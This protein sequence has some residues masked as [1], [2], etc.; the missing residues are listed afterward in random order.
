MRISMQKLAT[1]LAVSILLLAVAEPA[2][3]DTWAHDYGGPNSDNPVDIHQT[4]DGGFL[5]AGDTSYDS[6][7]F[8]EPG[9]YWHL[10]AV[11]IDAS[12]NFLWSGYYPDGGDLRGTG[13]AP[14]SDGGWMLAGN[15]FD[16]H[17]FD[18]DG[19]LLAV[20]GSGA[21]LYAKQLGG[22]DVDSIDSVVPTA[23]GNFITVGSTASFGGGGVREVWV[24]KVAPS[25]DVV[26]S[27][28]YAAAG[29]EVKGPRRSENG[30]DA[31]PTADG[32]TL[33]G[34]QISN[35]D[36]R[37][38]SANLDTDVSVQKIDVDGRVVWARTFGGG[39]T[40]QLIDLKSTADGG[41][42]VL[43]STRSA[44]L[45]TFFQVAWVLKLD[46][47][48]A[49][50]WQENL[51]TERAF[52]TGLALAPAP[53]GTAAVLLRSLA[54]SGVPGSAAL[55]RLGSLG[56]VLWSRTSPDLTGPGA[57]T[58]VSNG[59]YVAALSVAGP[60]E[61]RNDMRVV[62]ILDDGAA[63]DCSGMVQDL[64]FSRTGTTFAGAPRKVGRKAFAPRVLN[65][66]V[67]AMF[68]YA[69]LGQKCP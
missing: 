55:V 50:L 64:V 35:Q 11:R 27:Y 1:A 57:L 3:A 14:R 54:N 6:H 2:R 38:P 56:E 41:V 48:G 47:S 62:R 25:G 26:W 43:G 44:A 36:P 13:A 33:I 66:S 68:P 29:G 60:L 69:D 28:R 51:T 24:M 42:L 63:V 30:V 37:S 18:T 16:L 32:G 4:Q 58:R 20:D 53:D 12:G 17:D 23:D 8:S 39:D 19:L 10:W 31:E 46:A 61:R 67:S 34:G 5:I 7:G 49:I 21:L 15:R 52:T 59:D 40:D 9:P 45:S 65:A 22:T